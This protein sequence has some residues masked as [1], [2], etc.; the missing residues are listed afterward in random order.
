MKKQRKTHKKTNNKK[1]RRTIE[2]V[3]RHRDNKVSINEK[4]NKN[5]ENHN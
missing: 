4:S 2:E 5:Y 1:I 3:R